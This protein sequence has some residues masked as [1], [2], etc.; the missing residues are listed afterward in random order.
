MNMQLADYIALQSQGVRIS[1]PGAVRRGGAGPADARAF[2]IDGHPLMIPTLSSAAQHSDYELSPAA[3]GWRLTRGGAEL[4]RARSV[5]RPAFYDLCTADGIPYS[6]I[7]LLHGR[8]CLA[9]TVIQECVRYNSL[10]TRCR[11]CAIGAS[12]DREATLH[13]KTPEQLAE[14]AL[15]A[16]RLDHVKHVT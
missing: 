7:A 3:D 14:V 11:F 6:K 12:L 15:A 9:S 5:A 13:T 8:D 4:C 16:Q 2:V 10:R 1:E